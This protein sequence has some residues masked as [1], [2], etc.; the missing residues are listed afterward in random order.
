MIDIRDILPG[1]SYACKFK[2][3]TML[4]TF[5]RPPGLSDTPLEGLGIYEGLGIIQIR[6]VD[7]E[8]VKLKDEKSGKEFVVPFA[9]IWDV[10][11]IEWVETEDG[12][13]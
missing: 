10:D 9:Q 8:Q 12:G 13:R 4:D 7:S 6:D 5:G 3:E 1:G 2:T 11:E